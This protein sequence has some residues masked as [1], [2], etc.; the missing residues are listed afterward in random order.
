MLWGLIWNSSGLLKFVKDVGKS[1]T[2]A[3][4]QQ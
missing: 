1:K 2:P 3:F 4:E